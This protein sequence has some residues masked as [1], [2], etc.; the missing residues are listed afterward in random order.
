MPVVIVVVG[1]VVGSDE[2]VMRDDDGLDDGSREIEGVNDGPP[3][4]L[5]DGDSNGSRVV[6]PTD[7]IIECSTSDG[8][9][10]GLCDCCCVCVGKKVGTGVGDS[11]G[12]KLCFSTFD[13]LGVSVGAYVGDVVFF[14]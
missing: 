3:E 12:D 1:V 4:G 7:G 2:T 10:D 8:N 11:D 5:A 9:T 13:S 14:S 6:G